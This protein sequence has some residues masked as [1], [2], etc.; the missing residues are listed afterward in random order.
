MKYLEINVFD[1]INDL[2]SSADAGDT[3]IYGK[4]EAYSCQFPFLFLFSSQ[5]CHLPSLKVGFDRQ[6]SGGGQ[7][8]VQDA[9]VQVC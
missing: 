4:L 5:F 6:D 9:G 1:Q 8:V 3:R 7:E 2:L